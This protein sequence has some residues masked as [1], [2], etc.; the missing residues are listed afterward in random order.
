MRV[1]TSNAE[2]GVSRA[3]FACEKAQY[4]GIDL[5]FTGFLSHQGIRSTQ[6]E[7]RFAAL[8][9][10]ASNTGVL[11]IGFSFG[12]FAPDEQ[13]NGF[14]FAVFTFQLKPTGVFSASA[15]SLTFLAE[16]GF[17]L[18]ATFLRGIPYGD[19]ESHVLDPLFHKI[20]EK[21]L[22]VAVHNGLF[23]LL[24]ILSLFGSGTPAV[25]LTLQAFLVKLKTFFPLVFDTK[26][27]SKTLFHEEFTFL[28]YLTLKSVRAEALNWY[29][30][31]HES[32]W[33]VGKRE[34]DEVVSSLKNIATSP[35]VD[36]VT[37]KWLCNSFSQYGFCGKGTQC[38]KSHSLLAALLHHEG[39][40]HKKH[41]KKALKRKQEDTIPFVRPPVESRS[42]LQEF[43]ETGAHDA[44]ADAFCTSLLF[45]ILRN[46][47]REDKLESC[48]NKLVLLG[49]RTPLDSE[50]VSKFA[51][52]DRSHIA[53]YK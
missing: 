17:D 20:R 51:K 27:L 53:Y 4:V 25:P 24:L 26:Y 40:S 10:V 36:D 13:C 39:A 47:V 45:C 5:E 43:I 29:E 12:R 44:G 2:S 18:N 9:E 52:L 7:E 42:P 3:C 35:A 19:G 11:Q 1:D 41:E 23:D 6:A 32:V 15:D 48:A 49:H 37:P 34:M 21:K 22:P 50:H 14:T 31:L 30:V 28:S 46:K 16:H 33:L 8:R 38:P